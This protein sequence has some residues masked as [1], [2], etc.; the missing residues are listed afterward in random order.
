MKDRPKST[1]RT[2]RET[3]RAGQ[4]EGRFL[5]LKGEASSYALLRCLLQLEEL[6]PGGL[7]EVQV[8]DEHVSAD[9]VKFLTEEGHTVVG[10]ERFAPNVWRLDI[11]KGKK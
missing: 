2:T 1:K 11:E 3:G 9:L 4:R 6:K 7:L 10:V 8:G 5:D